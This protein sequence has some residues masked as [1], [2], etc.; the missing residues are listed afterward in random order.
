MKKVIW[1][2]GVAVAL[3]LLSVAIYEA[4]IIIFDR[5]GE[6]LFYL[7]QDLAFVPVQVLL[8]TMIVNEMLRRREQS[9]LRHKMNMVIGAFFSEMGTDLLRRF[10]TFDG[11]VDEM[12]RWVIVDASWSAKDFA[13]A[14]RMLGQH[15]YKICSRQGNL[16]ELKRFLCDEKHF[17]LGL[18]ENQNLLEHESFTDLLWAISHLMEELDV[19]VSLDRLPDNDYLHLSGDIER[20]YRSLLSAWLI[21][22][23][24]LKDQYPYIFSLVVRSNPFDPDASAVID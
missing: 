21:Y 15:N 18:L 19:R 5:R 3:V 7:L 13:S 1:N 12:R 23:R 11:N 17:V 2:A 16:T 4:Q 6:T 14:Q 8:V 24:H 22:V 10:I 20:A 9:I